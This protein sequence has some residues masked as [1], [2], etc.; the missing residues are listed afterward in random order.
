MKNII[1]IAGL[2]LLIVGCTEIEPL[3]VVVNSADR[4]L[5]EIKNYKSTEHYISAVWFSNWKADGNMNSY[6]STLPDSLDMIILKGEYDTLSDAQ[7][8]DLRCVRGEKGTKV[9]MTADFD[10]IYEQYVVALD[11]AE[12]KGESMAEAKAASEGREVSMGDIEAAVKTE[13]QKVMDHYSTIGNTLLDRSEKIIS[14]IGLDGLSI[15]MSSTGDVF[16]REVVKRFID[17]AGAK[18]HTA[19]EY[20]F[21]TVI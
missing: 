16:F 6:L 1:K 9:L 11:E 21:S 2:G 7:K 14:E 4:N 18:F 19:K 5:T 20:L 3:P 13:R 12:R 10:K 15:S 8:A 17:T